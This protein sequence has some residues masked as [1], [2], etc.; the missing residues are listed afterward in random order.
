M[1]ETSL[2]R[3][4]RGERTT[5]ALTAVA[6]SLHLPLNR[7]LT[8]L[9]RLNALRDH[10]EWTNP[11]F[12]LHGLPVLVVGGLAS[13]PLMLDPL[14]EWLGRIGV[15]PELAPIRYGIECGEQ[16]V[17]SVTTALSELTDSA[18]R[19]AVLLAHSRGGQFARTV[20]VRN[21]KLVSGMITLGSPLNRMLAVHPV[22]KAHVTVL[23]LAG[24]L[25]IPGLMRAGCLW[26]ACCKRLRDDLSGPFPADVPFVSVFSRSDGVVDWRASLDPAAR[27][28]E[29]GCTHAGLISDPS[30]LAVIGEE[31]RTLHREPAHPPAQAA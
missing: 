31:L 12:D 19:P 4:L 1:R 9:T 27:H 26:G 30:A 6:S 8:A 10:S 22:I 17:Q 18:G 20:A 11:R 25:G 24:T 13:S 2:G 16:A 3:L 29:V 14:L 23:G 15:R 28:V 7:E 5:R 21:A